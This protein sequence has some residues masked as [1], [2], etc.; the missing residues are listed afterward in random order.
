MLRGSLAVETIRRRLIVV[1]HLPTLP[2][3]HARLQTIFYHST[4]EL[5]QPLAATDRKRAMRQKLL[6]FCLCALSIASSAHAAIVV[7]GE[8]DPAEWQGA[9][10]LDSYVSVQPLTGEPAPDALRTTGKMLSTPEGLA[11]AITALQPAEFARVNSRVKR[12]FQDQVDRINVMLDFDGDGRTGFTFTVSA[13]NDIADE[14][15]TNEAKFANDWDGDW[16]HA[17]SESTDGYQYEILIPWT[18]ASM[19]PAIDG[20]RTIAVYV[21]RVVASTGQRFAMPK[22]SF[23]QPRFLSDFQRFEVAAF[24]SSLLAIT[25][26]GVAL[27]DLKNSQQDYK[28]GADIFWKPTNNHQFALT[29]N[30]DFGQVESDDLVVNFDAVEVFFSDKRPFFTDN[31]AAFDGNQ[32]AA[33]L[34]YTR[35]VGAGADDGSGAADIRGAIKANGNLGDF[36]YAVFAATED[37]DAGRDFLLTRAAHRGE[38]HTVDLTQT[39]VDRPFLNRDT[40]VTASHGVF[41]P[42]D[43]WRIDTSV[44]RSEVNQN[45]SIASGLGGG[46]I[47]D[48]DMPG[49]F[50]QQYFFLRVDKEANLNDMGFLGRNNFRYFE[51]ESGYRQDALPETSRFASHAW[52]AELVNESNLDGFDTRR[53][54]TL[55]RYS[56]FRDGSNMF[57]FVRRNLP[58]FDDLIS[59]GNGVVRINDGTQAFVEHVRARQDGGPMSFYVNLSAFPGRSTARH[60]IGFAIEPRFYLNDRF[61]VSFGLYGTRWNDWL[62]WQRSTELGRFRANR[63]D[64]ISDLNWFISDRQELRMK[65]QSIAIDAQAEQALRIGNAGRLIDSTA[66]LQDFNVRRLGFQLRYRYKLGNL[67]DV[68]VVYSRGGDAFEQS[69]RDVFGGLGDAFSLRDDDQFLVKLAY[70][71]EL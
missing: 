52:E 15:I 46:V 19:K 21:D 16:Q 6:T 35:R 48:W 44:Y 28:V 68:F 10:A 38:K 30:P 20:K 8:I 18:I 29:L 36:G 41:S 57:F 69:E 37:G 11:F 22:I 17:V 54:I 27:A 26:Y 40:T 25:P 43:Q 13:G 61:D 4:S 39:R 70:R 45:G 59:R 23:S 42:N 34:F 58:A 51:W 2:N 66:A 64:L 32:P 1:K 12:D 53:S 31:Q 47:A 9:I 65:L 7:D 14:V 5:Y 50:R 49:P 56:E 3:M 63:L 71:F 60:N 67:S 62:L 55:Q 33:N 24:S